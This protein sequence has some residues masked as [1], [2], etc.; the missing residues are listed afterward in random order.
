MKFASW[1]KKKTPKSRRTKRYPFQ[2]GNNISLISAILILLLGVTSLYFFLRS[3]VFLVR[4]LQINDHQAKLIKKRKIQDL[5]SDY[6]IRS[7]FS[8]NSEELEAKIRNTFL[9]I[10]WIRV[11]KEL[12]DTLHVSYQERESILR[13]KI[14]NEDYLVSSDG[15]IF[16]RAKTTNSTNQEHLPQIVLSNTQ[17][18]SESGVVLGQKLEQKGIKDL[19][20]IA[21]F[22][23]VSLDVNLIELVFEENFLVLKLED[24]TVRLL[25]NNDDTE[26]Q[27]DTLKWIVQDANRQAKKLE[28]IDLRFEKP[29]VRF[30]E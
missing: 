18:F 3:D 22:N 16:A 26:R 8:I 4:N 30:R 23:W 29:V 11:E 27:L 14:A 7:I 25:I 19:L 9:A 13:A 21:S 24:W 12:P 20:K 1:W 2:K 5:L 28:L 6:L 17:S 15:L 10:E